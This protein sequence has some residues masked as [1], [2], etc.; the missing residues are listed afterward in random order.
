MTITFKTLGCKVNQYETQLMREQFTSIGFKEVKEKGEVYVIN[1]CSVTAVADR[2][3]RHLINKALEIKPK[4]TV[5]VTGCGVD[6]KFSG[7]KNIKGISLKN[8]GEIFGQAFLKS[9]AL[10]NRVSSFE[11]HN[12]AF[13]KIQDGCNNFCSFCIIPYLRGRSR[14][15]DLKQIVQEAKQLADNRFKEIVLCGVQLGDY[16][17]DIGENL[18]NLI[19][20]LE[21]INGIERIRLSSLNPDDITENLI[22]KFKNSKKLCPH[23][24]ISL[25]SGDDSILKKMNRSYTVT[26]FLNLIKR[27]KKIDKLF[28]FTTDVLIG[29]PGEGEKEFLNT[30]ELVEKVGF[31]RVHIFSYSPRKGTK[32]A[33]FSYPLLSA[34][35][36]SARLNLLKQISIKSSYNYQQKFLNKMVSILVED[37]RDKDG[38]LKGYSEHYIKVFLKGIDDLKNK[39]ISAKIS[40]VSLNKTWGEQE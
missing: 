29:F 37:K 19:E 38:C 28:S 14:S 1:T 12:R 26:D 5:V 24:H 4:P 20:K 13:I 34:S 10:P 3:S 16:G 11:N 32:A 35:E 33:D 31:S 22:A 2:K 27:I 40:K 23:L 15:R 9:F 17:K 25:Q 6:N 36:I 21:E 8:R 39:I 18:V 7:I 30:V